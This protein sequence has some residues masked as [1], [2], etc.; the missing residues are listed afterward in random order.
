MNISEFDF[1]L[2]K[3][4]IAQNQK[5]PR[6]S[7]RLLVYN[8]KNQKIEHRCFSDI[9]DYLI[10]GDV[11]V[12]NNSKV[13]PARLLG[14]RVDSGGAVELLLHKELDD[15][16]WEV[17]G[18]NLRLGIEVKFS[19]SNLTAVVNE[20]IGRLA[21]VKFSL[22]GE[23]LSKEIDRIGIIPLPPYIERKR[24]LRSDKVN[25][26][27][28]YAKNRGSIAAPTAGLHFTEDL[29]QKI[30]NKG[31][32]ILEIELHVGIGTFAPVRTEKIESH[33]MHAERYSVNFDV[34]KKIKK[35]KMEGR[36]IIAVGTTTTRVLEHLFSSEAHALTGSTNIYIYPGFKF[37]CIN[38][39]IT[40]FHL[41]KSTLLLLVSAF[42]GKK[43]LL[44]V[45]NEAILKGYRFY[46][47]GD[48]MI[49]LP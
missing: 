21:I 31:I 2:P 23:K 11:L 9:A 17:L 5:T 7:S 46:S 42:I 15:G 24:I 49:V 27:T 45:Y 33:Q 19:A 1:N 22:S 20:K 35:A 30:K 12:L 36:R 44:R 14:L 32:E 34:F 40:N 10:S 4:L 18:K 13:F 16:R 6:D 25:Y 37:K 39:L 48:A 8:K 29:L 47:Y 26:Q 43:E 41:P 28:I 3:N 38:A